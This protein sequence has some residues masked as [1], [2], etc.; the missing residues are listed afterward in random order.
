MKFLLSILTL[1]ILGLAFQHGT[2]ARLR[3]TSERPSTTLS[4]QQ[5]QRPKIE[6]LIATFGKLCR[7]LVLMNANWEEPLWKC[8]RKLESFYPLLEFLPCSKQNYEHLNALVCYYNGH[9]VGR[10]QQPGT[11]RQ[12]NDCQSSYFLSRK[13]YVFI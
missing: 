12:Y 10:D 7:A 2:A 11:P 13:F 4:P 8:C 1:V 6:A 3:P 9:Y 5:V